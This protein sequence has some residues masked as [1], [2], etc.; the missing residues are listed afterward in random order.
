M[1]ACKFWR[2]C[3]DRLRVLNS[4]S[5]PWQGRQIQAGSLLSLPCFVFFELVR[6]GDRH[7][8]LFVG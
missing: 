7:D 2:Q 8:L 3:V 1:A 6:A 4:L 5:S